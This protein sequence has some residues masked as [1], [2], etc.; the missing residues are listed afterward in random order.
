MLLYKY[1]ISS[2][3]GR[4]LYF[5]LQKSTIE[6]TTM[7]R[8]QMSVQEGSI[9]R[10]CCIPWNKN[11]DKNSRNGSLKTLLKKLLLP[12]TFLILLRFNLQHSATGR[13]M[14]FSV[15]EKQMG[16]LTLSRLQIFTNA[17]NMSQHYTH[18]KH[19]FSKILVR[20][21]LC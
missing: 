16:V 4:A 12:T 3:V 19:Y 9:F 14:P 21:L 15:Y 20:D 17:Y 8:T 5:R 1:Q 11:Q 7:L 2:Q 10:L 6:S 13:Y 18:M